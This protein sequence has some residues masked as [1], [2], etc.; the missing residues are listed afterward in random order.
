MEEQGSEQHPL[1]A[2]P[3]CQRRASFRDFEAPENPEFQLAASHAARI[4][5]ARSAAAA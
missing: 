5:L 1:L 3:E 2:R 4:K